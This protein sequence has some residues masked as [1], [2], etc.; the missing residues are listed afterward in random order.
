MPS[1]VRA[2]PMTFNTALERAT[3]SAPSV[4][5]NAAGVEASRSSAIAA[6]QLPDPT[7]SV[8]IDNFPVSGPPAFTFNRDDM[9]M[10]RIGIEQAFPNPAKR[11]AQRGRAQAEIGV[12]EADLAV[13]TQNIRLET[14]L[15]WIATAM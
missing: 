6:G 13:E 10:A 8:G 7:L 15:A 12:A 11:R 2:E 4:Q 5:A 9:T 14:A 1:L 3:G